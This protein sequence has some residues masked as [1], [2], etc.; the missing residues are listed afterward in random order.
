[1]TVPLFISQAYIT[2][3]VCNLASKTSLDLPIVS[4]DST[5]SMFIRED[6]HNYE[7][8]LKSSVQSFSFINLTL[9]KWDQFLNQT[10]VPVYAKEV[11][12]TFQVLRRIPN[13]AN[14]NLK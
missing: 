12:Y 2:K 4:A 14:L 10:Q 9:S 5:V 3:P 11:L 6:K 8:L 7:F 13:R 1:M